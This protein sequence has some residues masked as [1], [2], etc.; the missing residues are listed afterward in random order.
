MRTEREPGN[1]FSRVKRKLRRSRPWRGSWRI[2][3]LM[4]RRR[5]VS[6]VKAAWSLMERHGQEQGLRPWESELCFWT[7]WLSGVQELCW[8]EE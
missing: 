8:E 6:V 4:M 1:E 5:L 2:L 3:L 7:G